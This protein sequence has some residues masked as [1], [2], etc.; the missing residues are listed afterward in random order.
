MVNQ[1]RAKRVPN[2]LIG[3]LV[4]FSQAATRFMGACDRMLEEMRSEAR[5]ALAS[6]FRVAILSTRHRLARFGPMSVFSR[7]GMGQGQWRASP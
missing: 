4:R 2:K 6:W 3:T 5:M 7:A 1:D